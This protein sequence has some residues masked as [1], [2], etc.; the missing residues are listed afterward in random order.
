MGQLNAANNL[1]EFEAQ[2]LEY[3][4][5]S[6]SRLE[7]LGQQNS[8]RTA[9]FLDLKK[10]MAMLKVYKPVVAAATLN[11]GSDVTSADEATE[12]MVNETLIVTKGIC[13]LMGIDINNPDIPW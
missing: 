2:A 4:I 8:E 10:I 12:R 7:N 11:P 3:E 6:R 5:A 1:A 13:D 9:G